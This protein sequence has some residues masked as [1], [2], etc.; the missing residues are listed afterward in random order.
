MSSNLTLSSTGATKIP[1]NSIKAQVGNK[2][3]ISNN[4]IIIGQGISYVKVS[5]QIYV[6]RSSGAGGAF[7][8][9]IRK[10]DSD[11]AS[12]TNSGVP[13]GGNRC[14]NLSDRLIPVQQNDYI[15]FH[16]YGYNGDVVRYETGTYITVEAVD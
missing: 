6:N 12:L 3:S 13:S 15:E 16:F 10:N 4:R 14:D 5:C 9:I 8:I 2:L 1:L 11:V 7:N